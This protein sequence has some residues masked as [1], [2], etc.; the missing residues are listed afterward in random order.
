MFQLSSNFLNQAPVIQ[1]VDS[2]HYP[3]DKSLSILSPG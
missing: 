2:E 1:K 3:V